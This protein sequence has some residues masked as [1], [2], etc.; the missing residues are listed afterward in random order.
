MA[1]R[2]LVEGKV[3]DKAGT[4]VFEESI[5]E[6]KGEARPYVSRGGMKLA[7]ALE[8]FSLDVSGSI[9]LDIGASTG[10]FTHCLLT[11][12]ALRVYAVDVGKNLIDGSLRSDGRVEVIEKCNFRYASPDLIHEE[13]DLVTVDVSFIS[14]THII[15]RALTFLRKD[16][17]ILL[18]V[19]PQFELSKKDVGK[20]GVV[21]DQGKRNEAVSKITRF[22]TSL[23][24]PV[25]GV[26]P[27][28]LTGPAGNQEYFVLSSPHGEGGRSASDS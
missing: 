12:G 25:A 9:C 11:H 19:K 5:I 3:T 20:G 2:V 15:P 22:L 26:L 8:G 18:L 13:V 7:G 16:G 17:R 1:G 27:S 4:S 6:I 10:G 23:N 28:P 24:V 21:R 14:L